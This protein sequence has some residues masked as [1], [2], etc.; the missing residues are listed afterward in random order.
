MLTSGITNKTPEIAP[1]PAFAE[2]K[3]KAPARA[4]ID[5]DSLLGESNAIK[6]AEIDKEKQ[7][8]GPGG[9]LRIG[10]AKTD[11][12]FREMLEKITGKK[13]EAM[14]NKLEKDDY[15]NLMVTQ[16]KYQDPTKPMENHEMATQLAQ[17]NTVEQLLNTNKIL[18]ELKNA[19]NELKSDKLTQ[20]LGKNI[21][22]NGKNMKLSPDRSVSGAFFELPSAVSTLNV[23]IKDNA[24]TAIRTLNL[25]S[26]EAGQHKIPWDGLDD[27]GQP[28]GS[29]TYTFSVGASSVDGKPVT[30]KS[31][32]MA[33]VEGIVD[34]ASG[35]KLETSAGPV[36]I[37]DI[38]AVRASDFDPGSHTKSSNVAGT[39]AA[40][41]TAAAVAAAGA[42]QGV[43]PE[44]LAQALGQISAQANS[45]QGNPAQAN[46]TAQNAQPTTPL[47]PQTTS[48]P[49]APASAAKG[50]TDKLADKIAAKT[51]ERAKERA[52]TAA[53]KR[54]EE[55]TA[56]A[57]GVG[58]G[59][60][61]PPPSASAL[62]GSDKTVSI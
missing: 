51:A 11:K 58:T 60:S 44:V 62:K 6:Q 28:M 43:P 1:D 53:A 7:I 25:G 42:A 21:Q 41:M 8:Q 12:E 47:P 57:S 59:P 39:P 61:T 48:L 55:R 37:K 22:V 45:A 56:E 16:L 34:L 31:T 5:F 52:S 24:G 33:K 3:A 49:P 50:S 30:A 38:L 54:R 2:A 17:F 20:Y 46:V 19:Q 35:G 32:Y 4:D 23:E 18:T 13:Q 27:K 29:G 10:E 36:E 40:P 26:L 9:E 15:L 14:K